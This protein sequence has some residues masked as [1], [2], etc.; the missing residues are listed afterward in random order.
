LG[1]EAPSGTA[2]AATAAA[3]MGVV[4]MGE[5]GREE[6]KRG[7]ETAAG[8]REAEALAVAA[9]E[10]VQEADAAVAWEQRQSPRPEWWVVASPPHG[11][12]PGRA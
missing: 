10:A 5:G 6:V 9:T 1:A 3:E 7:A 2:A 8:A 4:V 11:S 12:Q